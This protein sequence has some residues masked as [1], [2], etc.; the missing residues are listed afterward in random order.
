MNFRPLLRVDTL[1]EG[2]VPASIV[3]Q[4][5]LGRCSVVLRY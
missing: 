3:V 1:I 2:V 5:F 4:P